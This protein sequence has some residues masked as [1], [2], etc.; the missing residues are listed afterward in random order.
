MDKLKNWRC[1]IGLHRERCHYNPF[2]RVYACRCDDC[3]REWVREVKR[4]Y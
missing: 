4:Q 1:W 3:G 2:E